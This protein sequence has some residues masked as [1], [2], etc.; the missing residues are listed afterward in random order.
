MK[1]I[2]SL[3]FLIVAAPFASAQY[4]ANRQIVQT[5]AV[6]YAAPATVQTVYTAAQ[7]QY[8]PVVLLATYS[9][10]YS[11]APA[12]AAAPAP[13]HEPSQCEQTAAVL[14]KMLDKMDRQNDVMLEIS[15]RIGSSQV[16]QPLPPGPPAIQPR[17][18]L[19]PLPPPTKTSSIAFTKGKT[20]VARCAACHDKGVID[21]KGVDPNTQ[22]ILFVNRQPIPLTGELAFA[23]LDSITRGDMPKGQ[24]ITEEEFVDIQSTLREVRIARAPAAATPP[25]TK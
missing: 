2:L 18:Q 7:F 24:Q 12:V 4:C 10:A 19:E 1:T 16:P 22:P 5:Q 14:A 13:A 3:A 25:A 6:Q 15:R 20:F 11:P 9:A 23:C 21:S 17:Q 8:Q